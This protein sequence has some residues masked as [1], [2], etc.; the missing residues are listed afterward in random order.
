MPSRVTPAV[1]RGYSRPSD[2]SKQAEPTARQACAAWQRVVHGLRKGRERRRLAVP[3]IRWRL[4]GDVPRP[5]SPATTLLSGWSTIA[6]L[7]AW[8]L[9]T[10]VAARARPSS[11]GQY[12]DR[13]ER[14]TAWLG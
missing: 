13:V 10:A 8:W 1:T 14:I 11:L 12:V 6:E 7:S 9:Q 3:R 5:R 2:S 4:S